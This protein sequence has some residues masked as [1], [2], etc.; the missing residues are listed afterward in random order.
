MLAKCVEYVDR[1]FRGAK[2]ADLPIQEPT[3]FD[4]LINQKAAKALGLAI[5]QALAVRASR[6]IE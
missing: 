2:P 6:I 5:P 1:I 4:F 3:D